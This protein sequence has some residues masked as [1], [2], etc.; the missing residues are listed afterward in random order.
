MNSSGDAYY[1]VLY[2]TLHVASWFYKFL[3]SCKVGNPLSMRPY[4]SNHKR[5]TEVHNRLSRDRMYIYEKKAKN[6]SKNCPNK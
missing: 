2:D 1:I 4:V 6:I 5:E 3:A